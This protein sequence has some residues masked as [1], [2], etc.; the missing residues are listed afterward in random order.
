MRIGTIERVV[1]V[2]YKNVEP[3]VSV[4]NMYRF[5]KQKTLE[6][7]NGSD[8]NVSHDTDCS[9]APR[10]ENAKLGETASRRQGQ[11]AVTTLN[12]CMQVNNMNATECPK[13]ATKVAGSQKLRELT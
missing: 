2:Q 5:R 1:H 7:E 8:S 9:E 10:L 4:K 3:N 12:Q 13:P 11:T 6:T